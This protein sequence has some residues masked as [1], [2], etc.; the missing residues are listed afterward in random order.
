MYKI[1]QILKAWK[2]ESKSTRPLQYHYSYSKGELTLCTSQPGWFIG[3]AGRLFNK[4]EGILKNEVP[5]FK[6]VKFIETEYYWI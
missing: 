4:Y 2:T 3:A 1:Q 5:D 6:S